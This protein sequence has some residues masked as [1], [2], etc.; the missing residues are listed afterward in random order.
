MVSAKLGRLFKSKYGYFGTLGTLTGS[1]THNNHTGFS[2]LDAKY[3]N[4]RA[5]LAV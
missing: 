4:F 2:V 5:L 3:T 1:V